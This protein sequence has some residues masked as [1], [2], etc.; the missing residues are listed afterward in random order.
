MDFIGSLIFVNFFYFWYQICLGIDTATGLLRFV[1][2]GV[3]M[4]NEEK[5][6]FKDQ[7]AVKPQSLVGKIAGK[8]IGCIWKCN[9]CSILIFI[10]NAICFSVQRW[11]GWSVEAI[12]EHNI[13][14]EY[15]WLNVINRWYDQKNIWG[16][17]LPSRRLSK[18]H[19][20]FWKYILGY[21]SLEFIF[22][23]DE[24]EWEMNGNIDT[25][26]VSV[27]DV[28]PARFPRGFSI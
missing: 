9:A 13:Q 12:Q 3:E 15:I 19:T 23:W 11:H 22:S 4:E 6:Y 2:N 26:T 17:L 24:M 25:G 5:H 14:H 18:V 10:L 21:Q 1:V 8:N 28:C 27:E 16:W 20:F 7:Q